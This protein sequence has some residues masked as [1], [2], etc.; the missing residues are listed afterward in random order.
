MIKI[1]FVKENMTIM[2]G[3]VRVL[4]LVSNELAEEYE[5]HLLSICGEKDKMPMNLKKSIRFQILK[6]GNVHIRESLIVGIKGIRR[7]ILKNKIDVVF[8]VGGGSLPATVLGSSFL[9]VRRVFCEHINLCTSL[10]H[11]TD[12]MIRKLCVPFMD[13]VVTLTDE[14]KKDYIL[15]FQNLNSRN[16]IVIHNWMD[17]ALLN[18]H[19]DYNSKSKKIITVGRICEQK[20][21]DILVPIAA[22]VLKNHPDWKWEIY[23]AGEDY[24]KINKMIEEYNMCENIEM[25]GMCKDVYERY[26]EYA[27][28][29]MTS[30]FEGLPMVLLEAKAQKLPVI[31][32]DCKTGPGE[33]VRNEIDGILIEDGNISQYEKG[34]ERLINNENMRIEFSKNSQGN[35]NKFQK[36]AIVDQWKMMINNLVVLEEKTW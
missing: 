24:D 32:F 20:G 31:A 7:Y 36:E 33:I 23:G 2:D 13:R 17:E 10:S 11:G 28:Y 3:V 4:E 8:A 15:Q 5:V 19:V 30:R 25:M 22:D 18:E 16:V 26:K 34:L 9:N 6:E 21:F 14:D 12:A 27:F 35:I 1:C 29:A